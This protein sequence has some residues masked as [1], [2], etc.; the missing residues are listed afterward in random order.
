MDDT[1]EFRLVRRK[2]TRSTLHER[3]EPIIPQSADQHEETANARWTVA[4]VSK[5][6][7]DV[8]LDNVDFNRLCLDKVS[9]AIQ[10]IYRNQRDH[11]KSFSETAKRICANSYNIPHERDGYLEKGKECEPQ[12]EVDGS[13]V[14]KERHITDEQL[15]SGTI[16]QLVCYGLGNFAECYIAR[17]QLAFLEALRI[18]FE[19]PSERA[20]IYDPKFF[21]VE[22]M[23]LEKLGYTVLRNN[24]EGKREFAHEGVSLVFMPHCGKGLYNN[25]LWSN[26]SPRLQNLIIIGNSFAQIVLSTPKRFLLRAGNFILKVQPYTT[27]KDLPIN[28][29][30]S[31]VFNDTVI[32]FFFQNGCPVADEGFWDRGAEPV[33]DDED[34]EIILKSSS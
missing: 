29:K 31:D 14:N 21:D 16:S 9:C 13:S 5:N 24:E 26:W 3:K 2:R 28:S 4:S 19:V 17:C 22:K 8:R 12:E 7:D 15:K 23:V 20:L 11:D 1:S 33:Y 6:I 25:L 34:A 18:K 27:E 10:N 30:F 32:Q